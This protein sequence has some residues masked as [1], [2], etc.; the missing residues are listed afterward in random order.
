MGNTID[1]S[2]IKTNLEE[3][4]KATNL[5]ENEIKEIVP[6]ILKLINLKENVENKQ[7]ESTTQN[8]LL[9]LREDIENNSNVSIDIKRNK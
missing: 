4:L 9:D 6:E 1:N 8:F 5:S 3:K 7:T 2:T